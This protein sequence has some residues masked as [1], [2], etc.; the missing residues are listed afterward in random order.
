MSCL[1]E[2]GARIR[3]Y[4]PEAI[5]AAQQYLGENPAIILVDSSYGALE[6]GEALIICAS[7]ASGSR[8]LDRMNL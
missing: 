8:A 2:K 3:A 4:G 6:G 7:G 1:V 5:V